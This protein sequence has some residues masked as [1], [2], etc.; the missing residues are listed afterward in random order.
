[1]N[2]M[3][4]SLLCLLAL[5]TPAAAQ[6][7]PPPSVLR[8]PPKGS[9]ATQAPDAPM[10][11]Q[12]APVAPVQQVAPFDTPQTHPPLK[13]PASDPL[14]IPPAKPPATPPV[15]KPPV[16][17]PAKPAP[18]IQAP[19]N[20]HAQRA[21]AAATPAATKPAAAK[22]AAA[23]VVAAPPPAAPEPE[24]VVA[25]PGDIK[26]K[27]T[28]FPLPRWASLRSDE[29]NLRVGPGTQYPIK[30][31]YH[32][33]ELPVQILAEIDVWRQ[34]RDQDGVSGWV[35]AATLAGRRGFAVKG[36]QATLRRSA[37]DAT[38]VAYLKPGVVGRLRACD[39]AAAWC[40]VQ[41]GDYRGFLKREQ[42]YGV[43]PGEAVTN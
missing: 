8:L 9:S 19:P 7:S 10:V 4:A 28:G 41:V 32:R 25:K 18:V 17:K 24:P 35:H 20:V 36:A 1:M 5:A 30:W 2:L 38:P 27:V 11:T 12:A 3:R 21:P 14:L 23:P 22:P 13:A 37:D 40:E 43:D 15:A 33:R 39:G 26:G 29:V 16:K 6:L 42:F 34:I 31:L